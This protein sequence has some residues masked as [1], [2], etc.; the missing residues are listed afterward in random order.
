MNDFNII[1]PILIPFKQHLNKGTRK[2]LI[3]H[4]YDVLYFV[5]NLIKAHSDKPL[6]TK[7]VL[8]IQILTRFSIKYLLY[9]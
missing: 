3:S 1:W 6:Y 9:L 4:T 8:D 5:N 7:V 2:H